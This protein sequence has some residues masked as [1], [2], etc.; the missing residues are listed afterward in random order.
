MQVA[1]LGAC[2]CQK[3]KQNMNVAFRNSLGK[4]WH[5]DTNIFWLVLN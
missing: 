3:E 1:I 5:V 2:K 4:M